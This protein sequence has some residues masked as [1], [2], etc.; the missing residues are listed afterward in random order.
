MRSMQIREQTLKMNMADAV[1]YYVSKSIWQV[2]NYKQDKCKII[3][4]LP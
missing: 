3:P 2:F 1:I 4:Q